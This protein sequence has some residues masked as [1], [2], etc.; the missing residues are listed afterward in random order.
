MR[1]GSTATIEVTVS[2][3][4]EAGDALRE[5]LSKYQQVSVETSP[6]SPVMRVTCDGDGFS[7]E[8]L[9]AEDQLTVEGATWTSAHRRNNQVNE[10]Y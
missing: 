4:P 2:P 9:S 3:D 8:G 7:V 1:Q 5:A 6:V 10:A